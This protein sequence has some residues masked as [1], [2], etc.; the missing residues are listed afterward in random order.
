MEGF[1]N[2]M[3]F[4]RKH[5]ARTCCSTGFIV[6][7]ADTSDKGPETAILDAKSTYPVEHYKTKEEALLGHSKWVGRIT[8]G[9]KKG[10][11]LGDSE[12]VEFIPMSPEDL[13]KYKEYRT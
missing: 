13:E 10:K 7:T 4:T 8:H 2:F 5:I 1:L 3:G 6:S 9:L 12:E 11:M